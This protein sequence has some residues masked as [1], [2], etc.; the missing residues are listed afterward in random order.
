MPT[1]L[2]RYFLKRWIWPLLGGV[3]FF[4]GL[5][6]AN[7][8]VKISRDIFA[9]GASI[10]WLGPILLTSL[11]ETFAMVLP[12]AAILGGLIGTQHLSEG[13]EM[14]ASQGLGSGIGSILK[15]WVI[16]SVLLVSIA[17]VNANWIVPKVSSNMEKIENQMVEEAKTRF[18]KP[19]GSPYFPP[20]DPNTGIWVAPNG[21]VHLFAVTDSDVQHLVAKSLEWRRETDAQNKSYALLNLN[22]LK[23][24]YYKKNNQSVGLFAQKSQSMRFDDLPA[25]SAFFVSTPVQYIS[26]SELVSNVVNAKTPSLANGALWVYERILYQTSCVELSHRVTIPLSVVALL[27]FGIALGFEHPRFRR[28]G[29]LL[30]SLAVILCYY[31]VLKYLESWF[32]AGDRSPVPLFVPPFL[33]LGLALALL[34]KKTRPHRS[35]R[36]RLISKVTDW[37]DNTLESIKNTVS[38]KWETVATLPS[39]HFTDQS[40]KSGVL[41]RWTRSLWWRSWGAA[42]G[43]LLT[44]DLLMEFVPIAGDLTKTSGAYGVFFRY[45]IFNLPSFLTIAFPVS[46]LLGGVMAFSDAAIAREWTA[47]R[48]GGTSLVQ[49]IASGS[50]AWISVVLLTFVIQA[51]IAPMAVSRASDIYHRIKHQT[52]QTYQTKPWMH[53][54]STDV[55]WFLERDNRWGFSLKSPGFGPILY[56]WKRG[57]AKVDELPW[58]GLKFEPGVEASTLFPDK[59]LRNSDSAEET[60]TLDLFHWQKWAPDPERATLL[61]TRLLNW[62]AGPCLIFAML[63]YTF[64]PPRKGRGQVLGIALVVGLLFLGLQALFGGAA[65]AGEIPALWGVMAPLLFLLG[66]GFFNLHRLRT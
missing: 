56:R 33:F 3:V 43:T 15:P 18:L 48:A 13:S 45:W 35:S 25:P 22:D 58:D 65:R 55:L 19:G 10:R 4:G 60:S 11:P 8:L 57:E 26:T 29:A 7:N 49:W 61:W 9:Q 62:L 24:C 64:P 44:L 40:R 36:L 14:V 32:L 16:L 31:M 28:G 20:K 34:Y 42:L 38:N 37:N 54:T 27:L 51:G 5:M 46:F 41:G 50:R 21:E 12:M 63:A 39:I 17:G 1:T 52:V 6:L 23:G 59:A 66:F 53:L 30:K 2:L 47:L